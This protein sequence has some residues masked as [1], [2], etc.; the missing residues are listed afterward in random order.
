MLFVPTVGKSE[1][2]RYFAS[3][4]VAIRPGV[5]STYIIEA[6]STGLPNI[7]CGYPEKRGD[8]F[9]N[10]HL[11]EY[12]NGLKFHQRDIRSLS[13]CIQAMVASKDLRRNV[14]AQSR[15]H[16]MDRLN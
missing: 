16:V 9:D 3:A 14:G 6:M 7:L 8:A 5:P 12:R 2:S 4:D 10:E 1:L 13:N 15:K 11:L